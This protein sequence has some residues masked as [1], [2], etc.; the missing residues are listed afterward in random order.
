MFNVNVHTQ[1][2]MTHRRPRDHTTNEILLSLTHTSELFFWSLLLG[3]APVGS[4]F[5]Q[6]SIEASPWFD[7]AQSDCLLATRATPYQPCHGHTSWRIRLNDFSANTRTILQV[8][9]SEDPFF[10]GGCLGWSRAERPSVSWTKVLETL[11]L[12]QPKEMLNIKFLQK[13]ADGHR[14]QQSPNKK[15]RMQS[16]TKAQRRGLRWNPKESTYA[17]VGRCNQRK[18]AL[19]KP[20][21]ST[22]AGA[23]SARERQ[24]G[25]KFWTNCKGWWPLKEV[26][27]RKPNLHQIRSAR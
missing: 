22:Y 14:Y 1:T 21:G 12:Q 16:L 3:F 23:R 11:C 9:Q 6:R 5:S 7:P 24:E 2:S 4:I 15:Q 8:M 25:A 10:A 20:E 26:F 13:H 17:R 18:R 19:V 27:I